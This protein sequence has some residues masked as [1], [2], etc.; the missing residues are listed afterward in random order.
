MLDRAGC[1]VGFVVGADGGLGAGA[2]AGLAWAW[3]FAGGAG[4]EVGLDAGGSEAAASRH[5]A[6]AAASTAAEN[7]TRTAAERRAVFEIMAASPRGGPFRCG[8]ASAL[9]RCAQTWLIP[10]G[11]FYHIV[12]VPSNDSIRVRKPGEVAPGGL[13]SGSSLRPAARCRRT[14]LR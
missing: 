11:L 6:S 8:G 7:A 2:E 14:D 3:E 10:L 12:D 9:G 5:A 13:A 1:D 4:C